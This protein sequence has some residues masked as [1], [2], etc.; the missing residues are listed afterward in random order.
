MINGIF[1]ISKRK[2]ITSNKLLELLKKHEN[3]KGWNLWYF[4]STCNWILPIIVGEATNTSDS[5]KVKKDV[6]GAVQIRCLLAI[7]VIMNLSQFHLKMK[8]VSLIVSRPVLSNIR[9]K[10]SRTLYAVTSNV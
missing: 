1:L 8:K 5:S 9:L 2:H 6:Y 4:R 7:V 10:I 3:K